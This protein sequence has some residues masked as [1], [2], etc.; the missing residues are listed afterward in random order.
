MNGLIGIVNGV[1]GVLNVVLTPV[2]SLLD[3][4]LLAPLL[5]ALGIQL[6]YADVQLLSASCDGNARLVY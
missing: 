1:L 3:T 5:K 4:A 6:G 2:L